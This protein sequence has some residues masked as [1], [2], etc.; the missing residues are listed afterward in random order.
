MAKVSISAINN[1]R[2]KMRDRYS[3][4]WSK[5]RHIVEAYNSHEHCDVM[6]A[7]RDLVTNELVAKGLTQ[8]E[9]SAMIK[10]LPQE[11]E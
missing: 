11:I 5:D 2:M 10:I 7:I 8:E 9:C 6:Y 3:Y 1:M 4:G